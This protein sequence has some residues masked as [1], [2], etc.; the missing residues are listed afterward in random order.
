M[1][2]YSNE[3][4]P[5][6]MLATFSAQEKDNLYNQNDRMVEVWDSPRCTLTL[7]PTK[8]ISTTWTWLNALR[9]PQSP[10]DPNQPLSFIRSFYVLPWFHYREYKVIHQ[11]R[12]L[13][14]FWVV[15]WVYCFEIT[16]V[17]ILWLALS[18]FE[19]Y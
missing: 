1:L 12:S 9:R 2:L 8:A 15:I 13:N 7:A 3:F 11:T 19:T 6:S 16:E 18:D 4:F 14:I 5:L 17:I 10:A